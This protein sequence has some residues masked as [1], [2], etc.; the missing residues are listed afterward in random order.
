MTPHCTIG[1]RGGTGSRMRSYGVRHHRKI[2][3]QRQHGGHSRRPAPLYAT[4]TLCLPPLPKDG[5]LPGGVITV[6]AAGYASMA[7][8]F[9]WFGL[10]SPQQRW[11]TP[12]MRRPPA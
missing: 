2:G 12:G 10:R 6:P 11:T 7:P 3:D 8:D 4:V 1:A 5:E 9:R